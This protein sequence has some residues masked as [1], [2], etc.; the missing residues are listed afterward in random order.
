[1]TDKVIAKTERLKKGLMQQLLTRGIGHTELEVTELGKTPKEWQVTKLG[2][3]VI[4]GPQNGLYK[5]AKH[6]GDG[7]AI[8]RID[9]FSSGSEI[10]PT[11]LKRI[12]LEKPE[13]KC[14]SLNRGDIVLNRVNSIDHVGKSVVIRELSEPVVFES[15]MMRFNVDEKVVN[16]AFLV[17]YLNC[18][19]ALSYIRSNA[20]RAVHQASVN[21]EDVK[22][23]PIPVPPIEEQQKINSILSAIEAKL[24]L[25]L[26][27]RKK[28]ERTKHGLMDLLLTGKVRIKVD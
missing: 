12:R 10:E 8:V 13:L 14:Y 5:Q 22:S 16:P 7:I 25:E 17:T 20:K 23:I 11:T 4:D 24:K 28:L 27:E 2:D 6:Y 26:A 3:V 21:Q 15:N 18:P 19:K 1:L 9:S